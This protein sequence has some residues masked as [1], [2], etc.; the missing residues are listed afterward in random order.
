MTLTISCDN[1]NANAIADANQAAADSTARAAIQ[2][3]VDN[4]SRPATR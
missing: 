4:N 1:I 2:L 3:D